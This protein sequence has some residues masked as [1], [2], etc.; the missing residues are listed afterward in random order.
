MHKLPENFTHTS[1]HNFNTESMYVMIENLTEAKSAFG[2]T[3]EGEAV[4]FN[5]RIVKL[6]NF[7]QGDLVDASCV[8]NYADKRDHIPWRC[9]RATMPER[10]EES[11]HV[12]VDSKVEDFAVIRATM[13]ESPE[14]WTADELAEH[15]ED[16]K[17]SAARV[18]EFLSDKNQPLES[19][20]AYRIVL[21]D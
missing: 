11:N 4:F 10:A 16:E 8:P 19:T 15:L 3:D 21:P 1:E 20:E 13:V 2:V 14:W 6:L 7:D 12:S 18:E 5:A 17:I 9:V